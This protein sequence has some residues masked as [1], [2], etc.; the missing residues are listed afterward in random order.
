MD[1]VETQG[2]GQTVH[3]GIEREEDEDGKQA[4]AVQHGIQK[5]VPAGARVRDLLR[6]Y[7]GFERTQHEKQQHQFA[8][9]DQEPFRALERLFREF[10]KAQVI[11]ERVDH[12]LEQPALRHAEGIDDGVKGGLDDGADIGGDHGWPFFCA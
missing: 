4:D 5:I 12:R 6:R 2:P 3:Q 8:Q 7:H 9:A 11:H 1:I 10:A